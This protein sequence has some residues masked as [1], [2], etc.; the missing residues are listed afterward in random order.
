MSYSNNTSTEDQIVSE[1]GHT[2][3]VFSLVNTIG[4]VSYFVTTAS[5]EGIIT[6][7]IGDWAADISNGAFY[8]KKT[9]SGTSTSWYNF[10]SSSSSGATKYYVQQVLTSGN[11]TITH[12]LA[13]VTPKALHIE[14]RD[15]T[16]G[17]LMTTTALSHATNSVVLNVVTTTGTVNITII[18]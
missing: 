3:P 14:V 4:N 18:G 16:T 10:T 6:A 11:N 1:N 2:L 5:P 9:T 15:D 7:D 17:Q 13:L 8:I 12:N